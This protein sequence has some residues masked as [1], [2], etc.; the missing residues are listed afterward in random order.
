MT[1][2]S[3]KAKRI[4]ALLVEGQLS[5]SEIAKE[6][7]VSREYV[8]QL[9]HQKPADYRF[10]A[11]LLRILRTEKRLTMQEVASQIGVDA[12]QVARWE[13]GLTQPRLRKIKLLAKLF[14][15][16]KNNFIEMEVATNEQH[17]A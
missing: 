15:I 5:Q 6:V 2:R 1:I 12:A 14:G 4:L 13:N 3:A 16:D 10:R 7:G 9:V 17:S 11:E 8:N